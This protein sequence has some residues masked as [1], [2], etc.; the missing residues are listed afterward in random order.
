MRSVLIALIVA[1]M[2]LPATAQ[3]VSGKTDAWS[4]D[5]AMKMSLALVD[6]PNNDLQRAVLR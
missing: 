2:A 4:E 5:D 6:L 1:R 3:E